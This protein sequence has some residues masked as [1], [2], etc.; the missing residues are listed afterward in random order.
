M[1]KLYKQELGIP[2]SEIGEKLDALNKA[3]KANGMAV[4]AENDVEINCINGTRALS[5][6]LRV[7]FLDKKGEQKC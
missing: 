1:N 2:V 4:A 3:I 7:Y 5:V 6:Q